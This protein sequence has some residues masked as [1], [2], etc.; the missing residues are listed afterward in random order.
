MTIFREYPG[1]VSDD[2]CWVC[3]YGP[4]LHIEATLPRLLW[5]VLTEFRH[6]RHRG[7]VMR[8]RDTLPALWRLFR[9]GDRAFPLGIVGIGVLG[10]VPS[11]HGHAMLRVTTA[12]G[13]VHECHEVT[14][15]RD[16]ADDYTNLHLGAYD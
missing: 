13:A 11:V 8:V 4:Y 2:I 7:G 3:I 10:T 15:D 1:V 9:S 16:V 14:D 12:S 6:D 5:N